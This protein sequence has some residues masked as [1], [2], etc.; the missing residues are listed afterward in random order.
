MNTTVKTPKTFVR[1]VVAAAAVCA[2]LTTGARADEAIKVHVSYADLNLNTNAGANALY[3]RIRGAA[4]QVC[5]MPL[6][7][8]LGHANRIK[9]C[10]ARVIAEAVT[11]LDNANVNQVYANKTGTTAAIKLAAR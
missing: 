7:Q 8:D 4:D 3:Q 1:I 11:A 9:A 6:E 2:A 5:A 10:T